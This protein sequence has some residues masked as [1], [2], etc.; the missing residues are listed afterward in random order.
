[1][2]T[3][4]AARRVLIDAGPIVAIFSKQDPYHQTC[5]ETV[6]E[7]T[8]PLYTCWPVITE[9]AWLLKLSLPA[10]ERMLSLVDGSLMA[11]LPLTGSEARSIAT[12]MRRY[13][14]LGLQLAD[15]TLMYLADRDAIET[16]FT[17]DRRDFSVFRT[18][19]GRA[20]RLIP[21]IE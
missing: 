1:M 8:T 5:I 17:M 3:V 12:L 9:A 15:A 16:V 6:R 19:A 20:L 13:E 2:R 4:P 18:R 10:L 14:N 7:L 11:I 21:Q